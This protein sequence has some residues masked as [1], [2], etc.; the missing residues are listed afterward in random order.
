MK[1]HAAP[2]AQYTPNKRYNSMNDC[3][4]KLSSSVV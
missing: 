4:G 3:E 2:T 1:Y